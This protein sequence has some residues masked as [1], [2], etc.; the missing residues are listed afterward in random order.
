MINKGIDLKS[1]KTIE[2]FILLIYKQSLFI[3]KK[4]SLR[5]FAK[6]LGVSHSHLINVLKGRKNFSDKLYLK[7]CKKIDFTLEEAT[8]FSKLHSL[9]KKEK[10]QK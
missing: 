9:Y 4:Y 10:S 6:K 1:A 7:I 8:H 5:A 3:N 2:D